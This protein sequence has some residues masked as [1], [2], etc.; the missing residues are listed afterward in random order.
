MQ[1]REEKVVPHH[2]DAQGAV[3]LLTTPAVNG[4][5]SKV[6]LSVTAAAGWLRALLQGVEPEGPVRVGTHSCKASLLSMASKFNMSGHSRRILGY[7]TAGTKES[8]MLVYSRDAAAGPLRDLCNMLN[9][10]KAGKFLPDQTRSGRFVGMDPK[11]DDDGASSSTATENEEEVDCEGEEHACK[12]VVGEW[13]PEKDLDMTGAVYGV[14]ISGPLEPGDSLVDKR[15]LALEQA[16]LVK[17]SL[18]EAW[19]EKMMQSRLEEPSAGFARTT[20]KQLEQA[21]R[22]LFV[23]LGENTREGIKATPTGRPIDD[24]FEK[25]MLSTEVMSILQP[26]PIAAGK[27]ERDA[28]KPTWERPTKKQ[29]LES[30]AKGNGKG[31]T[32]SKGSNNARIPHELLALGEVSATTPKGTR[33]C[34][35]YNLKRCPHPVDKQKCERGLHCCCM[36]G[37]YKQHPAL[38]H[39]RE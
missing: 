11:D 29:R 33:L 22:K 16:N 1:L 32:K 21:D 3:P 15:A 34:F 9:I 13:R 10:I 8:S 31:K 2:A 39:G 19:S 30:G 18:M 24:V 36:R 37:C 4:G 28:P 6:P 38:D 23:V 7:H 35:G 25:C 5:W 26:R 14:N 17:F 12:N 27:P 20:M